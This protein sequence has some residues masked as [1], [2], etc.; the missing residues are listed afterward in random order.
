MIFSKIQNTV[1]LPAEMPHHTGLSTSNPDDNKLNNHCK[2]GNLFL[3]DTGSRPLAME[4]AVTPDLD[5]SLPS[6]ALSLLVSLQP[7]S[8]NS[9]IRSRSLTAY[10]RFSFA[11]SGVQDT[12]TS[13]PPAS[14][15]CTPPGNSMSSSSSSSNLDAFV[16]SSRPPPHPLATSQEIR[17][18]GSTFVGYI[19]RATNAEDA[20]RV[21]TYVRNVLHA[22]RRATHEMSAWRCM[23]L[24]PGKTGLGGPDD[25][26][27]RSG[28]E[29]DG[30]KYAGERVLKT[31]KAEG[32]MDA[33][34]I[35]SRWY[36]AQHLVPYVATMRRTLHCH[37]SLSGMEVNCW[38]PSGLHTSKL[39]HKRCVGRF[40]KRK[41]WRNPS[42]L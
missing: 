40:A 34:V 1:S 17:D 19:F 2:C 15:Q 31:M 32:A 13:P 28:S 4:M 38:D 26:E 29:D 22:S 39:A 9:L 41:K 3:G 30:E 10:I 23:V 8:S 21:V 12:H 24:K 14:I 20:K 16:T 7:Y 6:T 27:L 42:L 33:V 18:R 35:I 37:Q 5:N 11:S 36:V 25:F